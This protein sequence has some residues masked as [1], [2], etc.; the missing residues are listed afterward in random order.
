LA[1]IGR[2][3]ILFPIPFTN[4]KVRMSPNA[5]QRAK[6]DDRKVYCTEEE[7]RRADGSCEEKIRLRLTSFI[8]K[9]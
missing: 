5:D 2:R 9:L 8:Y 4:A 3:D 7:R 6:M 1:T